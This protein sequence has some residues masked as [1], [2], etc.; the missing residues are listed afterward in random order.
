[1]NE[2][3]LVTLP[4]QPQEKIMLKMSNIADYQ[5]MSISELAIR[6]GIPVIGDFD[7]EDQG[8]AGPR[9]GA[10]LTRKVLGYQT[11]GQMVE[12]EDCNDL[13]IMPVG[14]GFH[15]DCL[16]EE[17]FLDCA[18]RS[19]TETGEVIRYLLTSVW[20]PRARKNM[21]GGI[22]EMLAKLGIK[23]QPLVGSD[24]TGFSEGE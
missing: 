18:M 3:T 20:L 6:C 4:F 7:G 8:Y 15:M 13:I 16:T 11:I 22:N 17:D 14:P 2:T 12:D 9:F 5:H 23:V 24:A 1:M 10:E 21:P 19:E